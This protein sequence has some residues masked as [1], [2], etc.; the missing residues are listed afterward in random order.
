MVASLYRP[1]VERPVVH[2]IRFCLGVHIR[3][4]SDFD[5]RFDAAGIVQL[6][7]LFELPEWVITKH[8]DCVHRTEALGILLHRHSYSKRLADMRMNFGRSEGARSRIV[9]YMGKIILLYDVGS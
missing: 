6:S 7:S 8:C 2:Y 1:P 5:F 3:R 9:L 4:S